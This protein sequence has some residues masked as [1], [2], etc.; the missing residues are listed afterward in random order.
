[1]INITRLAIMASTLCR[2]NC[3]WSYNKEMSN[4]Y[5]YIIKKLALTS[6]KKY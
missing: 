3:V 1:M 4:P 6:I 5:L 2:I